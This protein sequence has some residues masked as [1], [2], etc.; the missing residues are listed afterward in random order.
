MKKDNIRAIVIA[1]VVLIAYN[2]AVFMIPCWKGGTFWVSWA[3]TLV[4][5]VIS[6]VA[7]YYSLLKRKDAKSRFYGFPIAKI[8]FIYLVAQV[9]V[10]GICM[11]LGNI[12]PWWA[13]TVLQAIGMALAVIGLI[14]AETVVEEI[15]VQDAKLKKNVTLM[16]TLQSKV[17]QMA[18]QC[19]DKAIKAL[20]EEFRYSDPV[21]GDT[22]AEIERDL[23][24]VVDE[25][26]SAVV[27][28]DAGA[29]AQLCRKASAVLAERNRLCKLNKN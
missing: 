23:S 28:G 22:L 9:A 6:G 26:Q 21:S 5:F 11:A 2:F 18:A 15:H 1:V 16:R 3:L 19:E 8:A 14:S 7:F 25:L 12:I 20:A 27:D 13:A 4:A 17:N 10:G 29:T 24:A